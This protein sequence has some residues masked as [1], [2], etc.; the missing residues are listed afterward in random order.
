MRAVFGLVLIFG[1]GL[2]GFAV[3]MAQGF[4]EQQ[5]VALD[6]ERAVAAQ[7]IPTIDVFAVTRE[8]A[9]GEYLTEEDVEMI[10]YAEPHLPEGIFRT[11]EE[12][13][14]QGQDVL[15]VVLTP[16]V[17]NE[18]VLLHKVSA[19]GDDAGITSRLGRGMRAFAISV[20]VT[21]GVSGF[22]H[23]GDRVDVYWSG[24]VVNTNPALGGTGEVTKLI[25]EAISIVAIDQ[26]ADGSRN[27]AT[28]A[29]TITVE[30]TPLQVA[31]L[32]QAQATG[33]LTLSLVGAEDDTVAGFI[34]V[35]Q[36]ALLGI[37]EQ[38]IV[39]VTEERICTI[40]TRRGA[41]VLEIPIPCSNN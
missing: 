36:R 41:E 29:R 1:L 7:A 24:R 10:K 8:I 39:A 23:P 34:E 17:P 4:F 37:Q 32:A 12:L 35:D 16:M 33:R 22:L 26:T 3:Y 40:R 27:Q 18:P 2:A 21:S 6:H 28:I 11:M 15:R 13:F 19:P 14:P 5:Q 38:Q 9:Y 30:A 31:A 20:D 25:E